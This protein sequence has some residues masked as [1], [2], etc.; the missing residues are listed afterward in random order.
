ME[1][2][3]IYRITNK[4]LNEDYTPKESIVIQCVIYYSKVALNM[5]K[6]RKILIKK[7]QVSLLLVLLKEGEIELKCL[8][9]KISNQEIYRKQSRLKRLN[10]K[11]C[12]KIPNNYDIKTLSNKSRIKENKVTCSAKTLCIKYFASHA[13]VISYLASLA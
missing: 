7:S 12:Q 3:P 2:S 9:K 6:Y 8:N 10:G 11:G 5:K 1:N 4:S 13:L